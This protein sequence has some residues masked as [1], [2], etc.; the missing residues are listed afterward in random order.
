MAEL[1]DLFHK[2]QY[3]GP[4]RLTDLCFKLI[5]ENLDI[6]SVKGKRGHRI[7]RKGLTFPS[8]ICDKIIE[9]AQR[10]EPSPDVDCFFSIFKNMTATRLKHVKIIYSGLTDDS[11]RTLVSHKLYDLEL[12]DCCNITELCIEHINAN[13]ENLHSLTCHGTSLLI[14]PSLYGGKS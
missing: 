10:S 3:V 9:Y 12:T 4:E 13:S 8:E 14:A 7:L 1:D 11:V 6:I 5:S 2:D